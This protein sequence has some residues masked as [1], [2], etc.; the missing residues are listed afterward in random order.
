VVFTYFKERRGEKLEISETG[1]KFEL[2]K[3]TSI[4]EDIQAKSLVG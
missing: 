2:P 1:A 3:G 4:I